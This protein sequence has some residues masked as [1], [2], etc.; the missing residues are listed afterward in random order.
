M[1]SIAEINNSITHD[2][3][4]Y[5]VTD[6]GYI[7]LKSSRSNTSL[8]DASLDIR[9][10]SGIPPA[11]STFQQSNL[12]LS[13][14]IDS[15]SGLDIL[16]TMY[17]RMV[18]SNRNVSTSITTV[19]P[20]FLIQRLELLAN[21]QYIESNIT[22]LHL[23]CDWLYFTKQNT[24]LKESLG[25]YVDP[26]TYQS[27]LTI[28]ASSSLTVFVPIRCYLSELEFPL[29]VPGVLHRLNFYLNSGSQLMQTGSVTDLSLTDCSLRLL[30]SNYRNNNTRNLILNDVSSHDHIYKF[31]YHNIFPISATT[32][33]AGTQYQT[34]MNISGRIAANIMFATSQS[35]SGSQL[36]NPEAFTS[37]LYIS[38]AS[39]SL[40]GSYYNLEADYIS[41]CLN[42]ES[43]DSLVANVLSAYLF[44]WSNNIVLSY[45]LGVNFGEVVL[46]PSDRIQYIPATNGSY[47]INILAYQYAAIIITRNKQ[48]SVLK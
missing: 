16:E 11:S 13:F 28:P 21:D 40:C 34:T 32:V 12:Q 44:S 31:L 29:M 9:P 38:S 36:Y 6:D 1:S 8:Q 35:P 2:I 48:V 43:I 18:L 47:T 3:N 19:V 17:L 30:G 46:E 15:N 33:V 22:P 5:T 41:Y 20:Q 37:L 25:C 10:F 26:T 7:E 23:W 24:V 39:Q 14:Q 45:E 42:S 27:N 4:P